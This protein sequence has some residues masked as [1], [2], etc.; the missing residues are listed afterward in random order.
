[1]SNKWKIGAF[2]FLLLA[3]FSFSAVQ[4]NIEKSFRVGPG[5]TLYVDAERG[6]VEVRGTNDNRV[7]VEIRREVRDY[8]GDRARRILDDYIIS[9]DQTGDDVRITAQFK[10]RTW[11]RERNRERNKLQVRFIVTVPRKYNI[12]C[13]TKGGSITAE[14]LDGEVKCKTSGGSLSFD[15][16]TGNINGHTSGGS[17]R[18][19]AVGGLV[20]VDTSGGSITIDNAGGDVTATTSGGGITVREVKGSINARTSGGSVKATISLQPKADCSLKTSGGSVTVY[21]DSDI[22]VS[23]EAHTSGGSIN[24]DF[25]VKIQGKIDRNDLKFDINGGGPELLLRT[26]GGSIYIKEK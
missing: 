1:M 17:I 3:V 26:S 8:S 25:P 10:D 14:N 13:L 23:V 7:D 22:A 5:G 9:F 18:I 19:G 11:S 4:D 15:D 16:V 21:L 2:L 24:T 12:D 20:N 6:S